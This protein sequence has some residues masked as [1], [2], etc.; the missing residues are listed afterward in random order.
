[1]S[2]LSI[3]ALVTRSALHK[4]A[5][6]LYP[7]E[8]REPYARTRGHIEFRINNC[9]FCTICATKCPTHAIVV[10]K[11]TKTWA[12]D[13]RLC[14]LCGLCVEGCRAGCISLSNQPHPPLSAHEVQ[15]FRED[16]AAPGTS[17]DSL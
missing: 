12:I 14:I 8:R 11:K 13:H 17:N 16:Y 15:Q 1:M 4:P 10:N 2:W 7:V 6:R 5:T 9:N 3:T